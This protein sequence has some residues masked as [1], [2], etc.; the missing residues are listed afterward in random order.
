MAISNELIE[1]I[2]EKSTLK[3]VSSQN[4]DGEINAVPKGSLEV[5]GENE[6]TY[7]EI[8]ESS[9]SYKN[10][11]YSIWFDKPVSVTIVGDNKETYILHGRVQRV[12][13]CGREFEN[14]YKKYKDA[15]GF[16]IAAAVKLDIKSVRKLDLS[17]LIDDQKQEHPF[18]SHYDSLALV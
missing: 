11:V 4:K 14:Y 9:N 12:L 17:K 7:V 2:K 13:T 16:D 15:R 5:T 6:L 1:L 10:I 8:L 3:I 18:F